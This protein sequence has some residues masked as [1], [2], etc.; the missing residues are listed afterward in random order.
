ML[1]RRQHSGPVSDQQAF[2]ISFGICGLINWLICFVRAF[3]KTYSTLWA[4]LGRPILM[5]GCIFLITLFSAVI[6][7][8]TNP[9]GFSIFV[10]IFSSIGL[11]TLPFLRFGKNR[12][13]AA[14]A[15]VPPPIV[16][17]NLAVAV[18]EAVARIG[19]TFSSKIMGI[20]PIPPIPLA[21]SPSIC[22][23]DQR[24]R[25]L[26]RASSVE[27][28]GLSEIFARLFQMGAAGTADGEYKTVK[29]FSRS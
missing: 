2:L 21:A 6:A 12:I 23:F 1:S 24:C 18:G 11:I 22:C 19:S 17:P 15:V 27:L 14:A 13:P 29:V 10:I 9:D 16:N 20:P 3:K 8:E 7:N 28:G 26:I 5:M 4:Y 25:D